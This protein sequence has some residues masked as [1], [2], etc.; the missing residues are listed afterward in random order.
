[1]TTPWP[2]EHYVAGGGAAEVALIALA[3]AKLPDPLPVSRG[4]HG[5]PAGDGAA[6]VSLVARE[7]AADPAWFADRVIAPFADMIAEDLGPNAAAL[8]LAADRAYVIEAKLDDPD[9][10]GHVQ[11]AW[12]LAKCVC[13]EGAAIVIDVFAARA[14]LGSEVAALAPDRAFDVMREVTL[15]FDEQPDGTVAAW[16]AGLRKFGRPDLVILGLAE[17]DAT[18][19]ALALRDV[20]ALLAAGEVIEPGHAVGPFTAEPYAGDLPIDGPALRLV[21]ARS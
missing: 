21:T 19:V 18:E 6:S 20:A 11:A 8:A 17:A 10:L 9:D 2:R 4:R 15:L 16:T 7:R 12:A 5:M 1:M 3:S 14:Y 13:E